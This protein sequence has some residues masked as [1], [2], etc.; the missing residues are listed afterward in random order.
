MLLRGSG[1]CV[2]VEDQWLVS[3]AHISESTISNVASIT[4]FIRCVS[5]CRSLSLPTCFIHGLRPD[6]REDFNLS[7]TASVTN[8]RR[9]TPC[10]AAFDFARRKIMSGISR[11]VFTDPIFPYL[12]DMSQK[13][14]PMVSGLP[15]MRCVSARPTRQVQSQLTHDVNPWIPAFQAAPS[16][17]VEP[18]DATRSAAAKDCR[19][20]RRT[21]DRSDGSS[22]CGGRGRAV[23]EVEIPRGRQ[24]RGRRQRFYVTRRLTGRRRLALSRGKAEQR[25]DSVKQR[26]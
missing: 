8:C 18:L 3:A 17:V 19:T 26:K 24:H 25:R 9:G 6:V 5:L 20:H 2:C 23:T 15:T 12:W 13:H 11:V 7:S 21:S 22:A 16:R 4:L 1:E 14:C 10:A